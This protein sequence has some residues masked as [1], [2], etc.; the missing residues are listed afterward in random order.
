MECIDHMHVVGPASSFLGWTKKTEEA[1]SVSGD[2]YNLFVVIEIAMQVGLT[3]HIHTSFMVSGEES[4]RKKRVMIARV[5]SNDDVLFHWNNLA[6][7]RGNGATWAH[8]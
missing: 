5:M 6:I 2:A 7:I 8:H 4:R 1:C 3:Q